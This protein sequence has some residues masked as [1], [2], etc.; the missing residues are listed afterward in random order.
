MIKLDINKGDTILT[1]K[2]KNHKEVVKEIGEDEHG[3]PTING[4]GILKIRIEKL[5]KESKK[6]NL[7][8]KL[9]EKSSGRKVILKEYV[10]IDYEKNKLSY[11]KDTKSFIGSEKGIQFATTYT[12]TTPKGGSKEFKF[13]HSTGPE[14][15]PKTRWVYKSDDGYTLE[16]C[17][18]AE[19]TKMNAAN[20]LK[21]KTQRNESVSLKESVIPED[22]EILA[23]QIADNTKINNNSAS[24]LKLASF[25]QDEES[26]KQ[27]KA[28]LR[29][30]GGGQVLSMEMV[31]ERNAIV[32]QMLQQVKAKYGEA[33]YKLI[34]SSF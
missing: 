12:L 8:T 26:L 29:A 24:A 7:L 2:W 25:L 30:S 15:D 13:T 5:M 22:I 17:N 11:N 28:I 3:L 31:S 20:Y 16:I 32:K 14:F 21:S 34:Y 27:I 9:L 6:I 1:G 23:S 10:T 18:D 33:A 4:K 19:I